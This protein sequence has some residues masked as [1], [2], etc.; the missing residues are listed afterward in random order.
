MSEN[1]E[2]T[3]N[4]AVVPTTKKDDSRKKFVGKEYDEK[5]ESVVVYLSDCVAAFNKREDRAESD[6]P[7]ASQDEICK[8][9]GRGPSVA[10]HMFGRA[11]RRIKVYIDLKNDVK[12]GGK[13]SIYG[14]LGSRNLIVGRT[15][16][17]DLMAG[18]PDEQK[19]K[20]GTKFEVSLKDGGIFFAPI[21]EDAA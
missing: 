21:T 9:L 4:Q 2:N 18:L 1:K 19:I 10:E 7:V 15:I 8:I 20:V 16:I 13:A 14:T 17:D 12:S 6:V 3:T 5:L 11:V